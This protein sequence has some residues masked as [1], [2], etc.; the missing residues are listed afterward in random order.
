MKNYIRKGNKILLLR[1]DGIDEGKNK[2]SPRI[3]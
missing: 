3:V 1:K 2:Y